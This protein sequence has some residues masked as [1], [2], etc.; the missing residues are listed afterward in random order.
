MT[1]PLLDVPA[2]EIDDLTVAY[3]REPALHHLTGSFAP[4]SL[5]AIIGPNGAGKSTL[6]KTIAGLLPAREGHIRHGRLSPRRI[7][8]LAQTAEIERDFPI[9]VRDV[10]SLGLWHELGILGGMTRA[11][12]R[13]IDEALAAV[14]LEHQGARA[15]GSLS[16]GQLQRVLFA[17]LLVQ[18]APII[19]LDEPFAAIDERTIADLMALITRWHDEGRTI[20][21]VLHDLE[22]VRRHFPQALLLAREPIAWGQ[23][24]D[25]LSDE[26]LK[27]ARYIATGWHDPRLHHDHAGVN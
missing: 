25:V 22:T 19:L 14:D 5:T 11:H 2:I 21:A 12:H 10:V 7:A 9:H 20:A 1:T 15:I 8:F 4:G 13:R 26:N 16:A 3:Q 27:R 18:D 24:P 17:R 23:T 6:L